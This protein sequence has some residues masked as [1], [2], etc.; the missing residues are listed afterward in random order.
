M[1]ESHYP[2]L[3]LC[4]KLTEAGFPETENVWLDSKEWAFVWWSESFRLWGLKKIHEEYWYT[5][6]RCPSIAELLDELPQSIHIWHHEY[7]LNI[8]PYSI[9]YIPNQ[10]HSADIPLLP[11]INVPNAL[12][13]MW[14]W[15]KENNYLTN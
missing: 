1:K 15:L 7:T 3:E 8:T 10:S 11:W 6:Y 14:L 13:E 12:T 2:S 5:F 4:K 9:T